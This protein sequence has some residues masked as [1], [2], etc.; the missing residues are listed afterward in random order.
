MN[1]A[2]SPF[3]KSLY[4]NINSLDFGLDYG[5]SNRARLSLVV[6]L[7]R[8]THSRFYADGLRHKVSSEGLGDINVT[9]SLWLRD[10]ATERTANA[11]I[12]IGIKTP[13]GRND[14]IDNYYV[15]GGVKKFTV[16]QSIQTGDGGWGLILEANGYRQLFHNGYGYA[17]GSYLISPRNQ[18]SVLQSPSGPYATVHVG[19]PDVFNARAGLA[20]AAWPD[21]GFSLSLGGRIDGI[22]YRDVIGTN[23][24]FR[25]PA[26]VGFIEPGLNLVRGSSTFTMSVPLLAYADFRPSAVD[27]KLGKSGGGDLARR[28][29]FVSYKRRM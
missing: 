9:G 22:P 19:V 24:A 26:I 14:G 16:D 25:R 21:R 6:P 10:P 1:E 29:Y 2:Q 11:Q 8:G 20:W 5:L 3:G 12:G 4:L 28:L 7:S 27:K 13:S 18:T 17:S 23:D 15:P